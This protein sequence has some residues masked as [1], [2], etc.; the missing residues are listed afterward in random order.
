MGE[1]AEMMLNGDLDEWTGEYLGPG[2]GFPRSLDPDH[3]SNTDRER[4]RKSEKR[5]RYR[6]NK[7]AR[8]AKARGETP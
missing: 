8:L 6:R 7:A 5:R 2:D 3:P 1:I 4:S